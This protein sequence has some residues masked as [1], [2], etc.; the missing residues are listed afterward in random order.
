MELHLRHQRSATQ[1]HALSLFAPFLFMRRI[2]LL[3]HRSDHSVV[4]YSL[5]CASSCIQVT[6]THVWISAALFVFLFFIPFADCALDQPQEC[7]SKPNATSRRMRLCQRKGP[8]PQRRQPLLPLAYKEIFT[9][10]LYGADAENVVIMGSG[11]AGYTPQPSTAA[12][13]T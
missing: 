8:R 6:R 13:I 7:C 3:H 1:S 12:D 11:P 10:A 2:L 9:A 5:C 4:C